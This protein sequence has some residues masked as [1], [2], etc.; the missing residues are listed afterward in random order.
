MRLLHAGLRHVAL[1]RCGCESPNPS[2]AAIE[3]ALQGNLCRCTGYEAIM[4]AARAIS[5]YGKAANDP[6][7]A[8]RKAITARLAALR[9]RRARRDRRGQASGWSCRPMSTISPTCS[10]AEPKATIVAGSTDVGLWVTKH[11]R[12]ISPVVFIGDL[13]ELQR[14]LGGRTASS[15]IGAG[16][17]YTDAFATLSQAH[18][19]ARA[20]DRPHRRRAGAQH[21]HDRRQ[22]RQRLADRRHA[23]AADRARRA[24]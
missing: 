20:A 5:S 17:T 9:R 21:G 6:L 1:R 24:A 22:H 23:A 8:E 16:V 15:R 3:K 13:D 18:P 11:M 4:R 7:A 10:K 14:D 19:G 12:D 2:D